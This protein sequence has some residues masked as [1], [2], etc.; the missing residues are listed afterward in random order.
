MTVYLRFYRNLCTFHREQNQVNAISQAVDIQNFH[1]TMAS[2]ICV[3]ANVSVATAISL[4]KQFR[5]VRISRQDSIY[6]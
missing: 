3:N 2:Q 5:D 4:Y 1:I 6:S